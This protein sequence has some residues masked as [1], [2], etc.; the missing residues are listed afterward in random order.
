MRLRLPEMQETHDQAERNRAEKLGKE[1]WEDS[2][3]V[4]YHQQATSS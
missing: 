2:D 3:G 4:F 1:G